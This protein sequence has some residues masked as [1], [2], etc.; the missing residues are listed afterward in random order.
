M[1]LE[2]FRAREREILFFKKIHVVC[3]A[4]LQNGSALCHQPRQI[5]NSANL[6]CLP[7]AFDLHQQ[8]LNSWESLIANEC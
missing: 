1:A 3:S 4:A 8:L 5:S 2:L 7:P 6:V